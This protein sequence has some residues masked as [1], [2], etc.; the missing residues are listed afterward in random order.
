MN[1]TNTIEEY[2]DILS[3]N[4][5]FVDLFDAAANNTVLECII[6]NTPIIVKKLEG[7]VEYLGDDYPLYFTELDQVNNLL[8]LNNIKKAHQY[9]KNMDKSDID[10]NYFIKNMINNLM[11]C[12]S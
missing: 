10:I 5:V 12:K 1:Y 9:L 4:I 7:V 8:E 2:D 6:R 11:S 3:Q